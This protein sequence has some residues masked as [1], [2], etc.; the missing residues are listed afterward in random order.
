MKRIPALLVLLFL[1]I[2]G[3]K[4]VNEKNFSVP[5]MWPEPKYDFSKNPLTLEK[6]ELGRALF[7]DPILSRDSTISCNSCHSQY[8]VFAHVDHTLSHGIDNK[9][10]TRNAPALMN[11]AWQNNFMWDGAINHLDMQPL[12][13]ISNKDEMDS[14]IDSVV[15]KL[16]R[17][18]IYPALFLKAFGDRIITGEHTLKAISQFM[19]TIVSSNSRYDSVMRK[20]K[21]FTEQEENGYRLFKKE[22][23]SCHAEPLFTNYQFENNG[24]PVDTMLN[25]FGRMKITHHAKDSLKFKVPSLRNIEFSYPY[26]HDGRFKHLSDVLKHYTEGIERSKTLSPQLQTPVIFS[27]NEKVDLTAFLLTLTDKE[28]LFNPDYAYPRKLFLNSAPR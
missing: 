11:L 21:V 10:G 25:D 5:D 20:Q 9:I 19:L 22:C 8:T 4:A 7:Y 14:R 26:M 16:Q 18:K 15:L 24:L 28:F 1:V 3:F 27:S 12:A 13:P 2:C 23:S 17:S 6:M